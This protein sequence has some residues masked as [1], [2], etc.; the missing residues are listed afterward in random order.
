VSTQHTLLGKF[1]TALEL[2]EHSNTFDL[3]VFIARAHRPNGTDHVHITVF[4]K[5]S[6][7]DLREI[8]KNLTQI[9]ENYD[10]PVVA[11]VRAPVED[12]QK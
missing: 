7:D 4:E 11:P 6:W 12:D 9:F 1:G 3:D 10:E 5:L 8:H 2:D